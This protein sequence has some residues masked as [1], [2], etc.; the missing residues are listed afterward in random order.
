MFTRYCDQAGNK[1]YISSVTRGLYRV[2]Q[3]LETPAINYKRLLKI[4]LLNLNYSEND[5]F[6]LI[7]SVLFHVWLKRYKWGQNNRFRAKMAE[8]RR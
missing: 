4:Q 8:N 5:D 6:Q 1:D 3:N 7:L 2:C